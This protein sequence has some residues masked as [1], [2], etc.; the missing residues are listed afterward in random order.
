MRKYEQFQSERRT[1]VLVR[2]VDVGPLQAKDV[3]THL[4]GQ[5]QRELIAKGLAGR[6]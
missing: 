3:N 4:R 6:V 5:R 2:V 1:V